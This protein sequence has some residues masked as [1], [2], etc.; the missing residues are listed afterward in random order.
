MKSLYF[1]Y[2]LAIAASTTL[3]LWLYCLPARLF[4][5]TPYSTV[6]FAEGGELL[7]AR[8]ADD[9]QW[10]FNMCDSLPYKF[11][12]ALI[13]YEDRDFRSHIGVS[14]KSIVRAMVQNVRNGRIVSGGSTIT[15]QTIRLHRRGKRNIAEKLV[16]IFMATR[17]EA[18]YSKDEILRLYASHAPFG[19]NVVGINA[20][21]WRYTGSDGSE[22]SWAQA[23]TLAVMQNA[24]SAMH[25]T[26]NRQALLAKRNRLLK[27]LHTKGEIS[28]D[29]YELALDEPLIEKPYALPQIA[30]HLVEYCHKTN[31]GA[32]TR[33]KINYSLQKR[34]ED[35][36]D[37][38]RDNL[39][40]YG[41]HDLSAIV[42]D[43]ASGEIVAYCGNA[44]MNADREG[45][46]VDI[47]RAP[48][49]SGSI[50]KP[51][52]YCAALQ[53][54]TILP[55]S[56]LPDIPTDFGG[57]SPQNFDGN[58]EGVIP[59]NEALALSLNVPNVH[60]LKQYGVRRFASLL[61]KSGITTLNRPA[62]EYGLS[63]ILGGAEVT[64]YDIVK[65]YASLARHD[66]S[67]AITDSLAIYYMFDAMRNINRPD[68]LDWSR[69]T[70]VQ[71][72]AWKT[73]TSWG[74][75]DA[76]A[77]GVSPSFV[78]GVWIG[79]AD[80]SGIPDL[81]GAGAAG[82]VMFDIFDFIPKSGWFKKP[83]GKK[84]LVCSHSGCLAGPDCE[85]THYEEI[86]ERGL[87]SPYCT[88][89]K[90]IPVSLDGER[91]VENC[92]EPLTMCSYFVL[93]PAE[94]HFY[95]QHNSDYVDLPTM[96]GNKESIQ[97]LYPAD[98]AEIL[99][100]RGIDGMQNSI[101]CKATHSDAS[102][103]IFWHLD[104]DYIGYTSD[105]HQI[106]I[107][108]DAGNHKLTII[109]GNGISQ[110]INIKIIR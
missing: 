73:G 48:R 72:V 57:F 4:D 70:S 38:W 42:A 69:A 55:H 30:P 13:E 37:Y 58:F 15:M 44:G 46:W 65:V 26:K 77:I 68:G 91:L 71:N 105:I 25:L 60:L 63:I 1:K 59:A 101:V 98:G 88:F 39:E 100:Q 96:S 8:I 12:K 22:L 95:K 29:E 107:C 7:G 43:V 90:K 78:V 41:A 93:P 27:R 108:P 51:L 24:P 64:L 94:R 17:L 28:D 56:I 32:I 23:A 2:I 19:G 89:C 82:P 103:A 20:A 74:A 83:K 18:T 53:E 14:L 80:G 76:W 66:N 5:G 99:L 6:V 102:A 110:S 106:S 36:A 3:L 40:L 104:N 52:L 11:E 85:S 92:N 75:R 109:D 67:A 86:P 47:A 50:L 10:R 81:T 61:Q 54:G 34:L 87:S 45:R 62:N 35:V 21:L 79:N 16:E 31:H 9:G 97:F 33:S 49:S 84:A